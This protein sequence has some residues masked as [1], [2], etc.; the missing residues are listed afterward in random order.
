MAEKGTL[1][2]KPRGDVVKHPGALRAELHVP[3]GKKISEAKLRKAEHSSNP[4]LKKRAVLAQ[5]FRSMKRK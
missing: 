5:T 4:T 3:A 2:G 1:F